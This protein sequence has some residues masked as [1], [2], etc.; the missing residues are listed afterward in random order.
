MHLNIDI[1]HSSHNQLLC[2]LS[3][4]L[5]W[6]TLNYLSIKL[7]FSGNHVPSKNKLEARLLV[8]PLIHGVTTWLMATL[9]NPFPHYK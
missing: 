7:T 6:A 9:L 8:S 3:L 1:V 5:F 2:L 4:L